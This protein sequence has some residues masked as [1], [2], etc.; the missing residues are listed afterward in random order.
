MS[1]CRGAGTVALKKAFRQLFRYQTGCLAMIFVKQRLFVT[2][3]YT[4]FEHA[5]KTIQI[6]VPA[7]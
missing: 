5:D 3:N 4:P 7:S 2:V 1:A 6:E